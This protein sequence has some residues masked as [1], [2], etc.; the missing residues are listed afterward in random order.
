MYL[1]NLIHSTFPP[2]TFAERLED[3]ECQGSLDFAYTCVR[4]GVVLLSGCLPGGVGEAGG[5]EQDTSRSLTGRLGRTLPGA[6]KELLLG[7]PAGGGGLNPPPPMS[8]PQCR[9]VG[10]RG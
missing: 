9:G 3:R 2:Q 8:P 5:Q 10:R 6:G 1:V 7:T 4:A